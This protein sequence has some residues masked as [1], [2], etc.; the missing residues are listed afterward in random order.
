[1]GGVQSTVNNDA[2]AMFSN[3]A[4]LSTV[5]RSALSFNHSMWI[6]EINIE[7]M[8]YAHRFQKSALGIGVSYLHMGSIKKYDRLGNDMNTGMAPVDMSAIIGYGFGMLGLSVGVNG[9]YIS[10]T[11]DDIT[12]TSYA[13]DF[14][15]VKE[16]SGGMN[17]GVAV[18]TSDN[19]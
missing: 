4:L 17:I 1:M 7:N 15:I 6:N 16:F 2:N 18:Q 13:F 3:P 14:G 5:S 10:S 12:A 11:L 19:P 8:A 9:K